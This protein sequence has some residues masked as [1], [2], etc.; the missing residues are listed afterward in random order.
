MYPISFFT[1]VLFMGGTML[2]FHS[3]LNFVNVET[4]VFEKY[5]VNLMRSLTCA[6]MTHQSY[7]T[8]G[9]LYY[10]K[11]LENEIIKNEF[12]NL[13]H[14]FLSYFVFD[15]SI[16]V[17]QV[18]KGIEK[19]YRIDLL[20]HHIVAISSLIL[21]N[22]YNLY[23][24]IPFIGLSE[25]MSIVSGPKLLMMYYGNKYWCNIFIMY[26]LFYI[27]YIRLMMI[28]PSMVVYYFMN[29]GC[30]FNK[31]TQENNIYVLC[32]LLGFIIYSEIKW[33]Y[34]GRM[35]LSRI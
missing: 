1:N 24:I 27:L 7:K 15:T 33:L 25:G 17:Y 22:N 16:M 8:I 31:D 30:K 19:R 35:E 13:Y 3:I 14:F 5:S 20:T 12:I 29:R 11:C 34:S 21:L 9:H 18:Y 32:T 23:G 26:R 4:N 28:W 6:I 2:L 10:D